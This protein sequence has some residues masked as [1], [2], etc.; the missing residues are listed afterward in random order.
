M[1]KKNVVTTRR[2]TELDLHDFFFHLPI[3]TEEELRAKTEEIRSK[4]QLELIKVAGDTVI[5][6]ELVF[7][8]ARAAGLDEV[9]VVAPEDWRNASEAILGLHVFAG[10]VA[11]KKMDVFGLAEIYSSWQQWKADLP[12][13]PRNGSAERREAEDELLKQITGYTRR[14][15]QRY[16]QAS[17]LS[18]TIRDAILANSVP[19]TLCLRLCALSN[20]ARN[21]IDELIQTGVAVSVAIKQFLPSEKI[22]PKNAKTVLRRLIRAGRRDLDLLEVLSEGG[23]GLHDDDVAILNRL[24][25]VF[26]TFIEKNKK[27]QKALAKVLA[28]LRTRFQ[29]RR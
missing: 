23:V 9:R 2:R 12:G 24:I 21:Q 3:P 25:N 5:Q 20:S 28:K 15:L 4:G 13:L 11:S 7:R 27:C 22:G 26:R 8:A 18:A 6:G 14:S 29:K 10:L 1:T 16:R 19:L 17:F